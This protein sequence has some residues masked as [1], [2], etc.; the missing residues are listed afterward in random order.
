M[1]SLIALKSLKFHSGDDDKVYGNNIQICA[2]VPAAKTAKIY[3]KDRK[4]CTD[5][6]TNELM[7][8]VK[9]NTRKIHKQTGDNKVYSNNNKICASVQSPR[10]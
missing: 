9:F 8:D 3:K 4:I 7:R 5:P 6:K 2:T 1:P 10:T